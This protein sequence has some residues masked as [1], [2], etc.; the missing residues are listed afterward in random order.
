MAYIPQ[1]PGSALNPALRVGTQLRECPQRTDVDTEARIREVLH[2]VALPITDEFLRRY[3]HQL[4]GGQQQRVAIAMAFVG[5]PDLIVLDEPTTG[6]DVTTQKHVL[7]TVRHMCQTY[8]CAAVYISHDMAVVAELADRI[9]VMY[10]GRIV[11]IGPASAVLRAPGHPYTTRL[12]MA[13][14]DLEGRR[15]S[16]GIPGQAPSP[17][18]R[19]PGC[20]FAPRCP[21]AIDACRASVPPLEYSQRHDHLVRC[22]RAGVDR[23]QVIER[24]TA[25]VPVSPGILEVRELTARYGSRRVLKGIDLTVPRG[26]CVALLGESGS[27][28]TTLARSIAGL[29][30]QYDGEVRLAG[31]TLPHSSFRRS[32]AQR[33]QVQYVFQNP[34]ESLNPRKTVRELV[35]APARALLGHIADPEGTVVA[36]LER[37]SLRRDLADRYPDQLSGGERQRVAIA[38]ALATGPD[39]RRSSS[40]MR[41]SRRSMCQCSPRSSSCWPSCSGGWD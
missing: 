20:A 5:R 7:T 9:A 27:G 17:M 40:A 30:P 13:V 32:V 4:S 41:S 24:V 14:P 23:L 26:H 2:E 35:L 11:E 31:E 25:S 21:L 38:R 15:Q 8:T 37:A 36:A 34:Y 39:V 29:H 10:S 18:D 12:L 3:P 16:R 22:I 1:S 28:K 19:P 6:L 33:R